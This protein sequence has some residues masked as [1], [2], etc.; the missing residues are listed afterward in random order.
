M[1]E[2]VALTSGGTPT[3]GLDVVACTT[4]ACFA[5]LDAALTVATVVAVVTGFTCD[6][7]AAR[8]CN[9]ILSLIDMPI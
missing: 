5:A 9:A 7:A 8:A 6:A 1:D 4:L 3:A 2:G